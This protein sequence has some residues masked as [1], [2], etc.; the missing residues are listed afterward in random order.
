[1]IIRTIAGLIAACVIA[2]PASAAGIN[3]RQDSQKDRIVQGWKSDDLTRGEAARLVQQQ[4]KIARAEARMRASGDGLTA[5]ERTRLHVRQ[6][7][8]SKNIYVKKHN[9]R[10]R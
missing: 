1:M 8:A 3:Q 5:A 7:H 10:G 2:L 6:D 4:R 9:D